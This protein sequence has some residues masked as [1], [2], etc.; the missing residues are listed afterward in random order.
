MFANVIVAESSFVSN[1]CLPY[2]KT[3]KR[4][5]FGRPQLDSHHLDDLAANVTLFYNIFVVF[6]HYL[7]IT[8][9]DVVTSH[10]IQFQ[11]II[12]T[13]VISP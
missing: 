9:G 7:N 11:Y 3:N 8:L 13:L 1:H 6:L 5:Y 4:L 10:W 2:P 12:Q